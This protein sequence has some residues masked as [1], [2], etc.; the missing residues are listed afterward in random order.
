M[1]VAKDDS[2][3]VAGAVFYEIE[4]KRVLVSLRGRLLFRGNSTN[5]N[6]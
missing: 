4:G 1:S 6:V 2:D 3:D 5:M